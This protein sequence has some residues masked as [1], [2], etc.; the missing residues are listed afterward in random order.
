MRTSVAALALAAALATPA[1]AQQGNNA[2]PGSQG[3]TGGSGFTMAPATQPSGGSAAP[4]TTTGPA[5]SQSRAGTATQ[6][7]PL[8]S[9]PGTST[10]QT[11]RSGMTGGAAGNAA[12]QTDRSASGD[13]AGSGAGR[14]N[15]AA[16]RT[17]NPGDAPRTTTTPA[18]GANSFTEGQAR[19]RIEAAGFTG[20]QELKKDESGVWRGRAMRGGQTAEVGLDYQGNVVTGN[21]PAR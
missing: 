7:A 9:T 10:I 16:V 15:Q 5:A 4:G 2:N 11:D 17:D 8:G 1:L 14:D 19:S 20:V 12:G 6:G 3:T 13:R 18:A 21:A